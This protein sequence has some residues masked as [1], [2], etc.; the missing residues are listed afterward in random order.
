ML[1]CC[2]PR[3]DLFLG[4]FPGCQPLSGCSDIADM[5]P[6]DCILNV[7]HPGPVLLTAKSREVERLILRERYGVALSDCKVSRPLPLSQRV[8]LHRAK[9]IKGVGVAMPNT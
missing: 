4:L 3:V 1:C 7:N 6:L 2:I 5:P 9:W 8:I